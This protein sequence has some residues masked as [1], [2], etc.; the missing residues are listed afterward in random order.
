MIIKFIISE[1]WKKIKTNYQDLV[2]GSLLITILGAIIGFTAATWAFLS[3]LALYGRGTA[4]GANYET[5]RFARGY[6]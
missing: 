5:G 4:L 6:T 3:Y 2:Y 1:Y